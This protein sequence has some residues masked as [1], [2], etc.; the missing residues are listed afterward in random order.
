MWRGLLLW[1]TH[2]RSSRSIS[3][4]SMSAGIGG[5]MGER[6]EWSIGERSG[7]SAET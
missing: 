3:G 4:S 1:R 6:S 7:A 2:G 5:Q